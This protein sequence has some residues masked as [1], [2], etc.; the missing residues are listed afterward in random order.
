MKAKA[1]VSRSLLA[2]TALALALMAVTG[3]LLLTPAVQA[4]T[5]ATPT[6]LR[7][8]P[9]TALASAGLSI[10]PAMFAPRVPTSLSPQPAQASA[11]DWCVAGSFQGWNN[12]STPLNDAG[13]SGDLVAGDGIYSRSYPIPESGRHEFKAVE[14]GIWDNAYP[15]SNAWFDTTEPGQ[16]VTF[17]FDTNDR[18]G[19]AGTPLY[20]QQYIVNVLGDTDPTA[21]TAVG[22]WQGW[23]NQDP[24][25]AM[26]A[27]GN[28]IH[29]LAYTIPTAGSYMGKMVNTGA[30]AAVGSDGLGVDAANFYFSTAADNTTVVFYLDMNQG[31]ATVTQHGTPGVAAWCVAGGFQGWDNASH[32]INDAGMD[33]DLIAGDG[34]YSADFVIPNAGREQFKVV[35]CGDWSNAFPGNNAWLITSEPNQVV[36]I[37]FDTND[38]RDDAGP[39][40]HPAQNIV[41]AWDDFPTS[42]AAVG[43]WQGWNPENP[44]T[45]MVP[46]G[47]NLFVLQTLIESAGSYAG[48]VTNDGWNN[49]I[50]ADGRSVDGPNVPFETSLANTPVTFLLDG[51]QSRFAIAVA[52]EKEAFPTDPTLIAPRLTYNV[53]NQFFY[54]VLTDRFYDGDPANNEGAFPGGT[55]A[56]TGYKPDDKSFYHGGDFVGLMGKLDYLQGLGVTALWITPPYANLPTQ[57]DSGTAFGIGGA[58]HGYWVL[59]FENADPHLGT[60]AELQALIDAAHARGMQVYFDFVTNHTADV[61]QYA[62][63]STTYR[64]KATWPYRDAD[65]NVF[66]DRDYAGGDTFPALDPAIS[67]PY[68]PVIPEGMENAKNPAWLNDPIYYHNRGNSTFAGESSTYGDFFGLD[69]TFTEHPVVVNGFIDI[70]KTLIDTFNIDGFRVDT[71]KHVNTEFWQQFVPAVMEYAH[72]QGKPDFYMFGEVFDGNP[73]TLSYYTTQGSFPGVLDFGLHGAVRNLVSQNGP[74]DNLRDFFARD[75]YYIDAN[76][77]AYG[78]GNFVSNHDGFIERLGHHLRNENPGAA[79]A[80]LVDRSTLAHGLIS[81]ARGFPIVYYGDE[82]GFVGGGSDKNAREDMFPSQ[83]Q[84]FFSYN[85]IGTDATVADDNFDET[86]PLY[87]AIAEIAAVRADHTALRTGAQLHRFSRNSTGTYAFSRVDRT[88]RVEYLV[89]LNNSTSADSATI[90]TGS[91]NITFTSLYSSAAPPETELVSDGDGNLTVTNPALSVSVWQAGAPMPCASEAPGISISVPGALSGRPEI[92]ATLNQSVYAEVTFA[93]SSDGGETYTIIGTDDNAPYRVFYDVS[94]HTPGAQLVFQA[95]VDDLCGNDPVAVAAAGAVVDDGEIEAEYVIFHYY[96]PDGDY[97]D[98]SSPNFNDFW[99]MHVWGNAIHPDDLNPSWDDPVRFSGVD[100][101]GAYVALRVVDPTQPVNYI[102]HRGNDKDVPA[103][104]SLN[105]RTTGYEVW[106]H[107]GDE[108]QYTSKAEGCGWINFHY[109]RADG[110][111]GDFDSPDFND[112]W[113]LHLW[114]TW[115][116]AWDNPYRATGETDFGMLYSVT[117]AGLEALI[118]SPVAIDYNAPFNFI[119]HRGNDKDGGSQDDRSVDISGRYADFWLYDDDATVYRQLGAALNVATIR[120]H[121][122]AGDYGDATSNDYNDFWGLHTWGSATDP[123]WTTPR[124]PDGQ[125]GFGIYFDVPL[126]ENATELN[127]ILHRGDEKDVPPDQTLDLVT[128]GY[129]IW[130]VQN[131]NG[132]QH[133]H[134]AVAHNVIKQVCAVDGDIRQERAY[135]LSENTIGWQ[136]LVDTSNAEVRLYYAHNGGL[137]LGE[138]GI[139]GGDYIVLEAAAPIGGDIAVK[140]P[141]LSGIPG[142]TIPADDLAQVPTILKG[143]TVVAAYVGGALVDATGLQ[144]PG[145]L[146][147]LYTY[148]GPLGVTFSAPTPTL[149]L[150]AP[151]A[152]N[153]TLHLFADAQPTT[154]GT[155]YSMTLDS[156]FGVWSIT[157]D[158]AWNG[159]YY[160]YE[161]EVYVH[162]TGR[163]ERNYVTDPYA[164]SL[165]MNSTRSQIVDL[166]APALAPEGWDTLVKPPLAAPEDIVVYEIHVRDFSVNDASV[167]EE[168]AGTFKAFTLEGTHGVQHLQALAKAGLTHLHLLPVFDIAT[169]N[170]DKSQWQEPD[171]ELLASFPPSSTM[172]QQLIAATGDLDGFNWG[173]DP[174]HYNVPEGSY[175]TVPTGTTRIVEFR[176]MVQ[177]L[178]K[179]GLRVVVDVVYNHT[180][181][182]GQHP[183]SVLDRIVPGYYHRLNAIGHVETSTCC[184]N[185]ATE[186][187]MME[188]LMVDSI[189][190]WATQYKVDAFRFDLMGHHMKDNMLNVRAALDALTL[191]EDGVNGSG[192]YVYGEGWNFGEV[193][194]NARGV[195]ATQLNMAGTGIGTFSDRLRDA[196]RGGGPFDSG[197]DLVRRQG[198]ISGLFYDPNA[199]NSG[200][201]GE[202]DALLHSADLI[203]VGLAGNL[204]DYA[205]VDRTGAIVTGAQVD[206]HGQPAGYTQDPQEHIVYI[207][208]HDNQTLYDII[209][210]KMPAAA[211][212][213]ARV[214]AQNVGLSIVTLSQGVP[215]LHAGSDML[216]SKSLD[217]DSYN[218]GDW[219]NKLDFTYQDNNWGVGLPVAEKNQEN[220]YLMEPLLANPALKPAPTDIL[221]NAHHVQELLAIRSSSPLF[222]LQTREDV[223]A[224]LAFH[225]TGPDQLPGLIVM[226][227]SD[228]VDDALD[229]HHQLIVVLINANDEP[230]TFTESQLTGF[231]LMLHPVQ[232]NSH[233][234]I[235]RTA[236]F[237]ATAGTFVVPGRT[238]AV[239][240]LPT[241]EPPV[242]TPEEMIDKLIQDVEQL[243]ADGKLRATDGKQLIQWLS[244]A[245]F[246]LINHRQRQAILH[247]NLFIAF[248]ERFVRLGRLEADYGFALIYK[249]EAIIAAIQH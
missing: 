68:T 218:S 40:F 159:Q 109:Q 25:T 216:R 188:R 167:P 149:H 75:D 163:V 102:F 41:H 35:E 8:D 246:H 248:V 105:V 140:F 161:V 165:S 18:S 219:F 67:F 121:R 2:V 195:N 84:E 108:T 53:Q 50:G 143:Q 231:D 192:I 20:P 181:A 45:Q 88:D 36:K 91:P 210:Y 95:V 236:T 47:N 107:S 34:V 138:D 66:D 69:D 145:V 83:V 207:S 87:L 54:F 76:S 155:P 3:F 157:G 175:S 101:C 182:A 237:D 141:H 119:V 158:P 113:G 221:S 65:G 26:E 203:R 206:Y 52:R 19:D 132:T 177:A 200:S 238:T 73:V 94:D 33:G 166:S 71:V 127:Y 111:Y 214:R 11:V 78:L 233:D 184:P 174:L 169:I 64:P 208:K 118:G 99:G 51:N 198:F 106:I 135:W 93:V 176:E 110:N 146:D 226:S 72:A 104:Q 123:G 124:R 229:P 55:L 61:I 150:W 129:E 32:P 17:L 178:N 27:L 179:M 24:A 191:A 81:F 223:Q 92:V 114:Q 1:W 197:D 98:F 126:F 31:R 215:F 70:A 125:D 241:E 117:P 209:Q 227:L 180:N 220:W 162:N 217:R 136:A 13:E 228:L 90:P 85:L 164:V 58:Y 201:A 199:M 213:E 116:T 62:E 240:V 249:A 79:D 49:Q 194:N 82:Q 21:F 15:G 130:I 196:V 22:D 77:N 202:K 225:N 171:W 212:M 245:K 48:K 187:A 190:L 230:Q 160:L 156:D 103:D 39:A 152:Q 154:T 120:Y 23:N 42:F 63:G 14:C 137:T 74:T 100:A 211:T 133:V 7:H 6:S 242:L 56:Q 185:T 89:V 235:V 128:L 204:A 172:Q 112:F 46:L 144:I 147:D 30:W 60:N 186:H 134:P 153:V 131:D 148:A 86:H 96:R 57:P 97:G 142:F 151:T 139:G 173:Y 10:S 59:D 122:C 224:R 170:E 168:Y 234:P 232:Q 244:Q 44:A 239:F 189:V 247:M 29:Y 9:Q 28:G 16:V 243:V 183:N 37:T 205:F 193:A 12:S 4:A 43:D 115:S 38:H 5:T 80:Q 222:R